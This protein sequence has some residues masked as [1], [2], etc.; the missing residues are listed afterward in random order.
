[1]FLI[2]FW[3]LVRQG[4]T[5]MESLWF[6]VFCMKNL[7]FIVFAPKT[8]SF[9]N[10]KVYTK[11][12]GGGCGD[13]VFCGLKQDK[14]RHNIM[15]RASVAQIYASE[16]QNNIKLKKRSETYSGHFRVQRPRMS[17]NANKTIKKN[18]KAR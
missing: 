9:F 8:V 4:K 11:D 14:T 1:M 3:N 6:Y 5:V 10:K 2:S 13:F 15:V 12:N 7:Y 16:P 18:E 17:G